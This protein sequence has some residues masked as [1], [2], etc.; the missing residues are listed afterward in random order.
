MEEFSRFGPWAELALGSVAAATRRVRE[1]A[2]RGTEVVRERPAGYR[3][4]DPEIIRAD[5]AAEEAILDYLK[6]SGARAVV[7]TEETGRLRLEG[8]PNRSFAGIEEGY[9]VIDPFDGSALYRRQ[10]PAF[11]YSCV[12]LYGSDGEP[13]AAAVADLLAG[14]VDFCN[15]QASYTGRLEATSL[16][17]SERLHPSE[18]TD[19][20]EAYLSVFVMK[21]DYMYPTAVKYMPLL[22]SCRYL[23]ANGGPASF[24][25]VAHGRLDVYIGVKEA[26]TEVFTGLP[27]A[28]RAGCPVT[29]FDG[30]PLQFNDDINAIYAFVCSANERLHE[31]VLYHLSRIK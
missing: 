31:Q 18:V 29:T 12:G 19:L 16:E 6:R 25:D 1:L 30:G 22:R 23:F 14:T 4:F 7:L 5:L 11:W 20:R 2:G 26:A 9:I 28:L 21:P 13:R 27:I 10:L 3:A 17:S 24:S 8:D 15:D